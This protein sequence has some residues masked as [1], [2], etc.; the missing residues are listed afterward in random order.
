MEWLDQLIHFALG[1]VATGLTIFFL[2][3]WGS[4]LVTMGLALAREFAQHPW[5][6]HSGCQ[7][8]L[9]F[10]LLGSLT[11]I[12]LYKLYMGG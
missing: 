12:G 1:A 3:W 10:W 5:T 2:P 6:C 7:L 4:L 8:D 9:V 11:V